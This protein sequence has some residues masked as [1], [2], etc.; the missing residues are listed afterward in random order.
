VRP[1]LQ[2]VSGAEPETTCVGYITYSITHRRRGS[3]GPTVARGHLA[4]ILTGMDKSLTALE[5]A[6]ALAKS[7]DCTSVDD[8]KR[9]LRMEGYQISQIVGSTLARQLRTLIAE[10]RGLSIP[11]RSKVGK[12]RAVAPGRKT[13]DE[14][15]TKQRQPENAKR[16]A[17][18]S[19]RKCPE[20]T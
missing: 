7:G 11:E 15:S 12:H 5:R 14:V 8:L 3:P 9:C 18:K 1:T 2:C 20:P 6:F 17:A 19:G 10:A 4:A 13:R 16:V